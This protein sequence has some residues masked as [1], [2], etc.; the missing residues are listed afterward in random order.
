VHPV[1]NFEKMNTAELLFD[2]V[3]LNLFG[4]NK[5]I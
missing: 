2:K 4:F 5:I 1:D 3:V